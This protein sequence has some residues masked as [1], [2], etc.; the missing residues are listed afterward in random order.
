MT[1]S[2]GDEWCRGR[3]RGRFSR[4]R[5]DGEEVGCAS[6]PMQISLSCSS[7]R[8]RPQP[9]H[10]RPRQ[11]SGQA[12]EGFAGRDVS[13]AG[14]PRRRCP[15]SGASTGSNARACHTSRMRS[16]AGYAFL[17]PK[18]RHTTTTTNHPSAGR[19]Y[20]RIAIGVLAF[21]TQSPRLH[22]PHLDMP[23]RTPLA[24]SQDPRHVGNTR[25]EP[26]LVALLPK[27]LFS[28]PAGAPLPLTPRHVTM[29]AS[30]QTAPSHS[31]YQRSAWWI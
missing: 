10:V 7:T 6:C 31:R 20:P 9:Q 22:S 27:R 1:D 5:C 30:C 16:P 23:T 21:T 4:L 2:S 17:P 28:A 11:D 3:G 13:G 29:P 26:S 14:T 15:D 24:P 25:D 19:Q 12:C 8:H 18:G